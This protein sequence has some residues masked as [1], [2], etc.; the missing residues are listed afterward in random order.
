[1]AAQPSIHRQLSEASEAAWSSL[2]LFERERR[3]IEQRMDEIESQLGRATEHGRQTQ[4]SIADA[5]RQLESRLTT[6]QEGGRSGG[7][8][9]SITTHGLVSGRDA[10]RARRGSDLAT[11]RGQCAG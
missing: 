4:R 7:G 5:L 10:I 9:D 1:M 11:L 3:Q 6:L 8:I 2:D